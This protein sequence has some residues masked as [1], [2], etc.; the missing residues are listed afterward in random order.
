MSIATDDLSA[1][2]GQLK[3]FQRR[4]VD[5]VFRR[6]YLDP[7]PA[8]RFLVAD[9][10]GLGKTMVARGVIARALHHLSDKVDRIDVVYVCSNATI[11]E[12]N[13]NRLNVLGLDHVAFATR[14]TMLPVQL[15]RLAA[16]R[17]NFVSF[18][19]GTTFDLKSRGGK[20]EERAVLYRMLTEQI[21]ELTT[22]LFNLLQCTA[23]RGGWEWTVGQSRDVIDSSI[24]RKFAAGIR[25]HPDLQ[26]RLAEA[27]GR[28]ASDRLTPSWA[29]NKLRY[30]LIGELRHL[31]AR[32]CVDALQPDLVILDEF[33]RF[34]DL[35]HGDG[36][37]AELARALLSYQSEHGD[38]VR[39]LLL[40]ATP[41]RM[42]S[43]NHESDEDHYSD[44]L[45]TLSFL[46]DDPSKVEI[47]KEALRAYR[48]GLYG[49]GSSDEAHLRAARD[50]I[51]EHLRTVM[52]RTERVGSTARQDAMLEEPHVPA[53]LA[54]KDLGQA[55]I[56]DRVANAVG[57]RDSIEYWKSAPYLLSFM[58][59]YDLKHRLHNLHDCPPS[60]LLE[61][62]REQRPH[63]LHRSQFERYRQLDPANARLRVL[64]KDTVEAGQWR[65]LWMPPSLPYLEP[66][67]AYA[68]LPATTKALV[69][70]SW[71][72]VPDA[73]AALCSYEAERQM[74][75]DGDLPG[76][77][78]LYKKRRPLLR[79]A[80]APDGRLTGMPALALLYPCVTLADSVDPL[81]LARGYGG[82]RVPATEARRFVRTIIEAKL[83]GTGRWPNHHDGAD[84]QRWYWAAL[85][86]LDAAYAPAVV[87]WCQ[88]GHGWLSV[89]AGHEED[90][91]SRFAQHVGLFC[92]A[93]SGDL[94]L[95]RAPDDLLD[96]LT[97]FALGSPAICALRTL[98]RQAPNALLSGWELLQA[99]A[100]VA[101]G[102]R[103]MFNLPETVGLLRGDEETAYWHLAL[104]HCIDGNLQAV[105]DEYAHVLREALGL[106]NEPDAKTVSQI[107]RAI[108]EALSVRTSTLKVDEVRVRKGLGRLQTREFRLRSRFALRFGDTNSDE[109]AALHRAGSVRQ[110]FNSPFRPFVLATTSVGQE[111]LDFHPYCH[112]VY[113]WNLPSNPVDLEQRE[114][115]VH[116]YKGHAVRKNIAERFG[117]AGLRL[118]DD[119]RTDPWNIL[120]DLAVAERKVGVSDLIPYWIY[121][122]GSAR[123]ERRVPM[124]P[125]SREQAQLRRLKDRLAMYRLVFGQP[126]QEDLLTHLEQR[127]ARGEPVADLARWRICLSPPGAET[128]DP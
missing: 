10:V 30:D 3:D 67:G 42:L 106:I 116:R 66:A 111:G 94:E 90:A 33:Q 44:F 59:G 36:D 1:I 6:M 95:G 76:Y 110:A 7:T 73:I 17:V 35:L 43:L 101:G 22:S 128:P 58:K 119:S 54:P 24:S 41:Y 112:V 72:V 83:R 29:D 125:Y 65:L 53:R 107:G 55:M 62:L 48:T 25:A 114:G 120:F 84:D 81:A 109:E 11:A 123:V 38:H 56:A 2:L 14:L 8:R 100:Q 51:E 75:G 4:T 115:R 69:F 86:L 9:E 103:T 82:A 32:V 26:L 64:L 88:R 104:K 98:G 108:A 63:L 77:R 19:P 91:D 60:D 117:L 92:Q 97:D 27:C 78:E 126:R 118:Q 127:T 124:L 99:A 23:T 15:G 20:K 122:N 79:F 93:L 46:F 102:F 57:A 45:R 50:D 96:V 71:N 49:L 68:E 28:F 13:I 52:V 34:K 37:A 113:H 61:V 105:L 12:Q 87:P 5:Y 85:A 89:G 16:N 74:L 31:L 21:P 18:T 70:S 121:E 47:A 40:S 39:V 80:A